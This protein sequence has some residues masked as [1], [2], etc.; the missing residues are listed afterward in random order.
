MTIAKM[1]SKT[2]KALNRRVRYGSTERP[3]GVIYIDRMHYTVVGEPGV[4]G[5]G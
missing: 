1:I 3:A 4:M 5:R 2:N